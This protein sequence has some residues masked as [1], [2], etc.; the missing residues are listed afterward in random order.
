VLE[1][2][3]AS[4]VKQVAQDVLQEIF[5]VITLDPYGAPSIPA[6]TVGAFDYKKIL[7]I[8]E[9]CSIAKMPVTDRRGGGRE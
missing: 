5:S 9:A 7:A 4:A 6:L 1:T 3:V 8:R 2:L